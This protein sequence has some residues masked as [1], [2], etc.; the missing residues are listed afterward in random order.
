MQKGN[1]PPSPLLI[2][3]SPRTKCSSSIGRAIHATLAERACVPLNGRRVCT[4]ERIANCEECRAR[5]N[6]EWQITEP[7]RSAPGGPGIIIRGSSASG[8]AGALSL[9]VDFRV[10]SRR[11]FEP[12]LP[13]RLS[14]S[15]SLSSSFPIVVLAAGPPVRGERA[16]ASASVIDRAAPSVAEPSGRSHGR[17]T[18]SC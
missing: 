17:R 9:I 3:S 5:L 18:Q 4:R 10:A 15:L 6:Y 12:E 14:L 1:L 13:A 7:F 16:D 11:E 2:H 8:G